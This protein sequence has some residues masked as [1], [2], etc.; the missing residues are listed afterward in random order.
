MS[1]RDWQPVRRLLNSREFFDPVWGNLY[2]EAAD[3][4][5]HGLNPVEFL[6]KHTKY[7]EFGFLTLVM[8]RSPAEGY[9]DLLETMHRIAKLA[10][11]SDQGFARLDA[12]VR[13]ACADHPILLQFPETAEG[14]KEERK[15]E[16]TKRVLVLERTSP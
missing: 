13:E 9:Y 3:S 7:M 1:F 5:T 11:F 14:W 2:A 10:V 12:V 6:E 4:F 8:Q 15:A 16:T